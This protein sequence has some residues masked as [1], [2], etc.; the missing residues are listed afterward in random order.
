MCLLVV[1]AVGLWEL[2]RKSGLTAAACSSY[3]HYNTSN[4]MGAHDPTNI[5]YYL[6]DYAYLQVVVTG[7]MA[8]T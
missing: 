6:Y 2:E 7:K 5:H 8:P 3:A 1:P 4:I